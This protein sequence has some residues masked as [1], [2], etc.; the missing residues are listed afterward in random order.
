M[1]TATARAAFTTLIIGLF[2]AAFTCATGAATTLNWFCVATDK[3]RSGWSAMPIDAVMMPVTTRSQIMKR[4]LKMSTAGIAFG[5]LSMTAMAQQAPAP[6]AANAEPRTSVSAAEIAERIAKADAAAKA[7]T[8][9][10]GGPLLNSAPF[11]ANMEYR[12]APAANVGIH[13]NDAE[14]FVVLEGEGTMTLGGTLVNPT[15]NG[16]NLTA[17]TATGGTP[18]KLVK[19]DMIL[20]P[21]N[22]AHGVTAVN[23]KLVMM[24]LHLPRPAAAAAAPASPA[25][26]R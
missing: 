7:G 25:P 23:G 5:L 8:Q 20:V 22:T 14:L 2:D 10:N 15:R 6:A 9:F 16:S 1:K 13:E 18:H 11:R 17:A 12:N 21:E 3:I 24:S 19:G 26:A 4:V